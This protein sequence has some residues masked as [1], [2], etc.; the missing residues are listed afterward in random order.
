MIRL[1]AI[2]LDGTLLTSDKQVSQ[3]N[4]LALQKAYSAGI[5][6]IIATTRDPRFV[7]PLCEELGINEPIVCANGGIVW[8]S[9]AGTVLRNL[10]IPQ[11]V[12]QRIYQLADEHDW[13]LTATIDGL[14]Y[15][16]QRPGQDLGPL[17]T[18]YHVLPDNKAKLAYGLP[19]RI[20]TWDEEAIVSLAKLCADEFPDSCRAETFIKPTGALHSLGI[21]AKG[22]DK[23]SGMALV[24]EKLGM[25]WSETMV[26]GD[27]GNDWPMFVPAGTK[28]AMSNGI[29]KLKEIATA[30][31]PTNDEDGVAWAIE[32]FCF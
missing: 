29:D 25:A 15:L 27:N 20:L 5:R 3:R 13:E 21:F 4:K 8:Q 14:T 24:L 23:G 10:V 22:A 12:A 28:V 26:I 17:G 6:I 7:S 30:I 32:R 11:P 31:A 18:R 1:V 9:P 16:R 19:H 2:D